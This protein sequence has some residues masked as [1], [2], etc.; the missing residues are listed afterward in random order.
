MQPSLLDWHSAN[1]VIA[2]LI[3]HACAPRAVEAIPWHVAPAAL[4]CG[5]PF[6]KHEP[7]ILACSRLNA[8]NWKSLSRV[9]KK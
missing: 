3:C 7:T 5:C 1:E 6:M 4:V 2:K 9:E 8:S